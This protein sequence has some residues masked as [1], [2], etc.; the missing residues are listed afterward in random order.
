[1]AHFR[2]SKR[3]TALF[4]TSILNI[5]CCPSLTVKHQNIATQALRPSYDELVAALAAQPHLNGDESP[6]KEATMKA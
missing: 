2:Q 6:T 1:M 5:P 4:V 3:R